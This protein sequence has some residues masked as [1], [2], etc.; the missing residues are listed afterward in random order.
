MPSDF[1]SWQLLL[2]EFLIN[3]W[4]L[5][6]LN[7]SANITNKVVVMGKITRIFNLHLIMLLTQFDNAQFLTFFKI[8]IN[9]IV[10]ESR[11]LVSKILVNFYNIKVTIRM[12]RN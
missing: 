2:K 9:M 3:W 4:H 1:N 6:F 11:E 8:S 12:S 5:N 7:S 10:T